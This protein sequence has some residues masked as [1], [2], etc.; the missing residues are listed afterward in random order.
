MKISPAG[1]QVTSVG[2]RK[3]ADLRRQRRIDVLV[4][5]GVGVGGFLLTPD[6]HGDTALGIELDDHVGAL[7][8]GPDV[9]FFVGPHR[10]RE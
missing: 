2:W 10:V 8:D 9:V 6:H 5:F 3:F 7:V 4:G 1:S